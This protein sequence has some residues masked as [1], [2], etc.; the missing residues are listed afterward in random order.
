LSWIVGKEEKM[1][2]K[3]RFGLSA[4]VLAAMLCLSG[5]TDC[6]HGSDRPIAV[7]T[8]SQLDDPVQ[9]RWS[10]DQGYLI[11]EIMLKGAVV[12]RI[13]AG[14][15]GYTS[16]E[17]GKIVA[18]R[19]RAGLAAGTAFDSVGP[20]IVNGEVVVR[21]PTGILVTVD[22]GSVRANGTTALQLALAWSNSIRV[23]L[24]LRPLNLEEAYRK[25]NGEYLTAARASWYGSRF[26]GRPTAS[27]EI[28]NQNIYTAAHRTL[29]FGSLVLV[30]NPVTSKTVLVRINDRGPFVAG[31]TIDLSRAAARAIGMEAAGVADVEIAVVGP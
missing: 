2:I 14:A 19:L 18:E 10:E 22:Q 24:G 16:E 21:L 15:G 5:S 31:R 20:G 1:T 23:G 25:M 7:S 17:R 9:L 29:P 11:P 30:T 6:S 3:A 26:H 12:L 27:G 13:R 4:I 8:P 28:Y